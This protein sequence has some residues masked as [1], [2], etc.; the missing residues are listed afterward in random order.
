VRTIYKPWANEE[1]RI[2]KTLWKKG[3]STR[4][5]AQVL[6]RGPGGVGARVTV[7]GLRETR[8]PKIDYSL[9]NI[10]LDGEELDEI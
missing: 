1:D 7:L 3:V 6:N 10:L 9:L 4:E 2:L 8:E 5:I